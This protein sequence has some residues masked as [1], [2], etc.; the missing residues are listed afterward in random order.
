MKPISRY[1]PWVRRCNQHGAQQLVRQGITYNLAGKDKPERLAVE[2]PP[3]WTYKSGAVEMD[4]TL[5]ELEPDL[6]KEQQEQNLA[7]LEKSRSAL[8]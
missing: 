1:F 7:A 6:A 8:G 4:Y 5:P 2:K 3:V